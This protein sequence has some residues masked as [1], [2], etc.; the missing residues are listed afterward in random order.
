MFRTSYVHHQEDY[1]VS[2]ALY[3]VCFLWIHSNSVQGW[4][5]CWIS[6][7]YFNLLNFD[8]SRQIFQNIPPISNLI[9]NPSSASRAEL[10][11]ADGRI[12]GET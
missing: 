4:R 3:G 1:I 6:M 12:D 7:R 9:K 2:A 8:F 10:F 5:L 11:H